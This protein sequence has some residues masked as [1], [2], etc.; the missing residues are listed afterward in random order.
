[1]PYHFI[2]PYSIYENKKGGK[3]IFTKFG[4]FF[5]PLIKGYLNS[6]NLGKKTIKNLGKDAIK[7]GA[8]VLTKQ[9]ISKVG[10]Q[11]EE[12][13]EKEEEKAEQ[14]KETGNSIKP[15]PL[16]KNSFFQ[17]KKKRKSKN[18]LKKKKPK[19]KTPKIPKKNP[20]KILKK[21]KN[22]KTKKTGGKKQIN[23]KIGGK[24]NS[25]KIKEFSIFDK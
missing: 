3:D 6:N 14:E 16:K 21:I 8:N 7:F 19:K 13:E 12:K 10:G 25:K 24:K 2:K 17:K 15:N 9:A 20:K 11:I 1:M 4:K 18:K 5:R 22:K 23:K